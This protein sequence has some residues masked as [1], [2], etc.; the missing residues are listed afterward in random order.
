MHTLNA[1]LIG[2]A[3][4]AL[5]ILA[6]CGSSTPTDPP[7]AAPAAVQ[8]LTL[9]SAA[10]PNVYEAAGTVRARTAVVI[11]SK[12][13]AYVREVRVATG[14]RVRE[15]QLLVELDARDLDAAYRQAEAA[16]AEARSGVPEADGAIAGAQASL[17]L[18][19][20]TYKRMKELFDKDSVSNQE[21]D[22]AS[23]RLKLAQS[24]CQMASA[25]RSQLDSK[26]A[27]AGQ[28]LASAGVMRSYAQIAAP[29][30]G[31]V[32]AKSVGPGMLAAPGAPLLTI[33]REGAYRLEAAVEE[34]K[35]PLVRAG[36]PVTVV[37]D[38][39]ARPIETRVSEIVPAIDAASRSFTVK[40]GLPPLAALRSGLFGRA[41]FAFGTRPVV[42]VP[43]AAVTER[44][45][46]A[47]VFV[48]DAGRARSRLV[49]LG[50]RARD[51]VEI[52]SGL[53]PG[54]RV[55]FPAP[56]G[57]ADGAPVEVRP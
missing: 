47:S 34:S 35:L 22:E 26:L 12:A 32:T 2:L 36:Q 14:D 20:A 24:G 8:V 41:Q 9:A 4:G 44:G 43:A 29:F 13:T 7:K 10:W 31:T 48:A 21:L 5:L 42:S 45:Q 27:Q 53:S 19:Q 1:P 55:I 40:I 33:E 23:A 11:S 17:A 39:V 18:A 15:G 16:E 30:S 52:L 3:S 51:A 57:L 6:G 25:R 50:E 37:L 49:T 38:A 56:P 46:L 28:A 54:E